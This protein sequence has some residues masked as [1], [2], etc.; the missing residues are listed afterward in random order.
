MRLA[1]VMLVIEVIQPVCWPFGSI[2][3]ETYMR[4]S[5]SE[6]SLRITFDLDAAGRAAAL[7]LL[8]QQPA[9]F[10]EAVGR[11]VGQRRLAADQVGLGEAGH[12]AERRVHVGDAAFHVHRAHA[13]Q[14]RVLHRA[15]EVGLR[16]Q[17]A[18]HLQAP[19][20]VAPGAEQHPDGQHRER[21][22]HPEQR[23]ADQADRGAVALAAQHQAVA[24]RRHRHL[25]DDRRA[26]GLRAGHR[27]DGAGEHVVV[28]IEQ[29][30]RVAGRDFLR[31]VAPH[32]AFDRVL[33]DQRAGKG[34]ALEQRHLD[35]Q[36]R[37]AECV[38][39]GPRVDRLALRAR[40][41][42]GG[43]GRR[44]PCPRPA[45]TRACRRR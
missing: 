31:H 15:A 30:D 35:L 1:S 18:L 11:P 7:Q 32:Q 45:A 19:A 6:P 44:C 36:H 25:V 42:E 24:G 2:S 39:E 27:R 43:F 14:H 28:R 4:A 13:G 10:F 40:G 41:D 38:D 8:L 22:D 17:R 20:H 3:G 26:R 33:G 21:D 37:V 34:A 5:N 23:V 29:R 9:V 12:R 16:H